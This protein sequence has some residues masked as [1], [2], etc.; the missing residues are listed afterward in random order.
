MKPGDRPQPNPALKD[1]EILIGAWDMEISEA[2][3]LPDR[4]ATIHMPVS[5]EWLEE[6]AFL[7]LRMGDPAAASPSA[8]WLICRDE[9]HSGYKAFYYDDRRVSRIYQM[10]FSDRACKL[11]RQSPGFSQRFAGQVSQD[12]KTIAAQWEK[13]SDGLTWEHDFNVTYRARTSASSIMQA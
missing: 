9:S 12:E 7:I 2:D 11:W 13:S 1:L 3:F 10:S 8:L 4:S 6:E 5:F